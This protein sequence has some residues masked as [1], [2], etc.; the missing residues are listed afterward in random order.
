MA[1]VMQEP[2]V[3]KETEKD[4]PGEGV[5]PDD[6]DGETPKKKIDF[7]KW[8]G[9]QSGKTPG[10]PAERKEKKDKGLTPAREKERESRREADRELEAKERERQAAQEAKLLERGEYKE[11]LAASK[12][13]LAKL[14]ASEKARVF[15][16]ETRQA[17][18]E[19]NLDMFTD[20]LMGPNE[21]VE[22]IIER[23]E[24]LR[25]MIDDEVESEVAK[26][27]NTGKVPKGGGTPIP[28]AAKHS[29]MT[30]NQK[31][32][33]IKEYGS[34]KFEELIEAELSTE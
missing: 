12:K 16:D 2:E 7:D 22:D 6:G 13:D 1:K 25:K 8:L 19:S 18:K 5:T 27:L 26:R 17:L 9:E 30:T 32:A 14:Q 3:E 15:R 33:F 31:L 24:T 21:K 4:Q 28:T 34:D 10:G 23:G 29:E 20:V 11:L